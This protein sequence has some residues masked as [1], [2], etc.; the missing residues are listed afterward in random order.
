MNVV[1]DDEIDFLL[2]DI[3][4]DGGSVDG[5]DS[6]SEECSENGVED[7]NGENIPLIIYDN[8]VE[9]ADDPFGNEPADNEFFDPLWI[10]E[11]MPDL[12]IQE[13]IGNAGPTETITD[14]ENPSPIDIYRNLFPDYLIDRIVFE[15][16]L[17]ATQKG[18]PYV[19]TTDNEIRTFIGISILMGIK[20]LP[21]YRDYWSSSQD[22]NDAYISRLMPVNRFGWLLNN[23]HLNDNVLQPNRSDVN[24]DKLY[25]VRP[26]IDIISETFKACYNPTKC[27]TVD[28]SMVKFKGRSTL[29]QYLKDKPIKRGYKVWML[30]CE[31]GYN[32]KFEIYTGKKHNIVEKNLGANVVKRLMEGLDGKNHH[33]YFDNYFSNYELMTY[34]INKQIYACGTVQSNRKYLPVLKGDRCM[35][36]GEID[37]K[38]SDAGI[39]YLKWMDNRSVHILSNCHRGDDVINVQRRSKDGRVREVPCPQA[40]QDYNLNMNKVDKFNQLKKNYGIDKRS[41]KWWLRI[42]WHLID[43]CIINSFIIWKELDTDKLSL[44]D[45]RRSI[46]ADYVR[47]ALVLRPARSP[48][49]PVVIKKNKPE[50]PQNIRTESAS[51]QPERTTYRRCAM[52]STKKNQVRTMWKCT[53]CNV[54]LCL[55]KQKNCFQNYHK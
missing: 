52:C 10:N 30:C 50:V 12:E 27:V 33:V 5:L 40:I 7:N 28:E 35:E 21:Y 15:T 55:R 41:K 1:Q 18:K 20:K 43:A 47:Y 23:I 32:Y 54:P 4:S 44:K 17:Y 26:L 9:E 48:K 8:I 45:F 53:I 51:H 36:R 13:F 31:S 42:F 38:V 39:L 34:L 49:G 3:P 46:S 14:I 11:I 25:K 16:N 22:L 24:Y 19:P 29:K 6:E 2:E 37:W